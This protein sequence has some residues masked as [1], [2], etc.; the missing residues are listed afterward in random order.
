MSKSQPKA[1]FFVSLGCSKNLVDTEVIAGN[2]LT[3]NFVLAY[4]SDDAD[5]YVINTC[6]FIP[7]ARAEAEESIAEGI[8]WKK[9]KAG[10]Q[11]IVAGCLTAWDKSGEYRDKYP[12]VDLWT[13]V[14]DTGK[15][16]Q[17]LVNHQSPGQT[18]K[19]EYLY[20]HE[21]PRLQLTLPHLAFLKIADGCDN[22]CTYCSIPGIRGQ[23]RSRPISSVVTEA[24]GLIANGVKELIVIAQDITAY[25]LDRKESGE[26]L[27]KLLQNL[28]AVE[29]DFVIRLLYTHPAHYTSELIDFLGKSPKILPYLDMPLQHI[30]DR[31]L[32]AMGRKV[33]KAQVV[34]LIAELRKKIPGL[35]LRTTFITGF[36]GE[37][38]EEF[39]ELLDFVKTTKFERCGVFPYAPEPGTPAAKF[40]DPVAENIANIRAKKLMQTQTRL[41][42]AANTKQVG[43]VIKILIDEVSGKVA[44]G[45]GAA[46]APDIDNQVVLLNA[47]KCKAGEFY[48]VEITGADTYELTAKLVK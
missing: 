6:A 22:C 36:P 31:I 45:R 3:S 1:V 17:Y 24:R 34:G 44:V 29:G 28:T 4:E 43:K 16:A 32:K 26:T 15:I 8:A 10:R 42:K 27:V 39:G 47:K 19:A 38:D 20:S 33:N 18:G 13:G 11:L 14:N 35:T 12:E 48:E 23:L 21:T 2:F 46:D 40:A 37:T 7:P 41:M 30:N 25:G 9:E 5:V